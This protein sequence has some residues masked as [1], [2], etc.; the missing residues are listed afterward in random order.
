[1]GYKYKTPEEAKAAKAAQAKAYHLKTRGPRKTVD[2]RGMTNEELT[3]HNLDIYRRRATKQA[4]AAGRT[5]APK[6]EFTDQERIEGRRLAVQRYNQ[7]RRAELGVPER[8]E[9]RMKIRQEREAAKADRMARR[10]ERSKLSGYERWRAYYENETPEQRRRRLYLKAIYRETEVNPKVREIV[11]HILFDFA[12]ATTSATK[13][14][15]A[16]EWYGVSLHCWLTDKAMWYGE[17]HRL[18]GE[19]LLT[20]DGGAL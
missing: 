10:A 19:H 4:A 11:D 3:A 6:R 13:A 12:K 16:E 17:V 18:M 7:R 9:L 2:R 8:A 14:D 20:E 1:M 5:Y 15:V